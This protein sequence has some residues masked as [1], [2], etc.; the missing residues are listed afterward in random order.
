MRGAMM[1]GLVL[2]VCGCESETKPPPRAPIES[3]TIATANHSPKGKWGGLPPPKGA[4]EEDEAEEDQ[5][6]PTK[7]KTPTP[8]DDEVAAPS[9]PSKPASFVVPEAYPKLVQAIYPGAGW[10]CFRHENAPK[11][12]AFSSCW[13]SL[14]V[15]QQSRSDTVASVSKIPGSTAKY[16][17]CAAQPNAACFIRWDKLQNRLH[18]LCAA[19]FSECV[20][21]LASF[22]KSNDPLDFGFSKGCTANP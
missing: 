12:Y 15:C 14:K 7:P 2:V 22:E 9:V 16:A 18:A 17:L 3:K 6:T 10:Q 5:P 8:E 13:R 19:T 4:I 1:M 20:N 11:E 21:M